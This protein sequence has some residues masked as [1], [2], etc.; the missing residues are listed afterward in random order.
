[1]IFHPYIRGWR[2][3]RRRTYDFK[4][5]TRWANL[6]AIGG[7]NLVVHGRRGCAE[8]GKRIGCFIGL[9]WNLFLIQPD[10]RVIRRELFIGVEQWLADW[11]RELRFAGRHPV[12]AI[13]FAGAGGTRKQRNVAACGVE[14]E[15]IKATRDRDG[16]SRV[17][18]EAL[19]PPQEYAQPRDVVPADLSAP[20]TEVSGVEV[21]IECRTGFRCAIDVS[22]IGQ[23][24]DAGASQGTHQTFRELKRGD[25][26]IRRCGNKSNTPNQILNILECNAIKTLC[27]RDPK[28][29]IQ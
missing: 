21:F 2:T 15:P 19:Q 4:S 18:T 11:C 6:Q 29:G 28:R 7:D 14:G 3:E 1:M 23:P 8:N 13:R 10:G 17:Y 12:A 20:A 16:G 27:L 5:A 22:Q 26:V 24:A 25:V 9:H